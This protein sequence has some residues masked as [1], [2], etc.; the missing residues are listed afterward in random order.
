MYKRIALLFVTVL[1]IAACKKED[2]V[3]VNKKPQVNPVQ[4]TIKADWGDTIAIAGK[5]LPADTKVFFNDSQSN[6]ISN[7]GSV[8][9]CVVPVSFDNQVTSSV[10][11]QYGIQTD[12]LKNYVTLNAPVISSFTTTQAI[13][14]TVII[15]GNHFNNAGLQVVFGDVTAFAVAVS[16][17]TIKAVVPNTIKSV[18]ETISVTSQL[19]TVA[20]GSAF[21]VLAPVITSVTPAAFIGGIV[22]I[23]GKYFN[24]G[25]PYLVYLDGTQTSA[26]VVSNTV[27]TF[28]LPYKLYPRRKTTVTVKMLEDAVTYPIDINV[29]DNWLMVSQG[30]PFTAYNA[31]PLTV[32]SEVYIV[33]PQKGSDG[34]SFYLWHFSQADFSWTQVGSQAMVIRGSYC[35][36]TNGSKIYLYDAAGPNAFYECD[37]ASGAWT[38]KANFTGLQRN[39]PAMFGIGGK[40]YLGAGEYYDVNSNLQ[41]INDWYAYTPGTNSWTRIADMTASTGGPMA[42][43]QTVVVSNTAYVLCG[44]WFFDYKYNASNNTWTQ[45]QN[46]LQPMAQCGVVAYQNK[47]YTLK[48]YLV[49]NV[50]NDNRNIFSYDIASD[51]WEFDPGTIDPYGDELTIGF[52]SNGKIYMLG[53]DTYGSVEKLYEALKLPF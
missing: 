10:Y 16:K 51:Q 22:T 40:L 20:A 21:E 28:P 15:K 37:P 24:P 4:G 34:T 48:G 31:T 1:L 49:Q 6:V 19:Q 3:N 18:H 32:G 30:V 29:E 36:G 2:A 17:Q 43:A 41:A 8:I 25:G 12:T 7:D 50:G 45:M 35:T 46:M 23:T 47:L 53:Y 38:A 44:G 5:N 39:N 13:G 52:I 9:K 42:N 11:I 33:A 26:T 27:I 14:D